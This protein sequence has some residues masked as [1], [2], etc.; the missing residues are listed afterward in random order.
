MIGRSASAIFLA[1]ACSLLAEPSPTPAPSPANAKDSAPKGPTEITATKEAT[2]DEKARVAVFVGE[3]HVKDPQ[4]T[5]TSKKLTAYLKKQSPQSGPTSSPAASNASAEGGLERAV[6]EE[7]VVIVQD[8]PDPNGGEPVHYVGKAAKADYDAISGDVKLTGWPQVQ[9][10]INTHIA[11][12][13]STIMILNRIGT[14][15]T[16]GKSKTVLEDTG[17]D[18][19]TPHP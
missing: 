5:L 18:K 17:P 4:F 16:Y 3:V 10:G 1:L 11:T 9:Q 2:F 14:I 12:E 6:A 15:K 8:K 13:E 7:E 19:P